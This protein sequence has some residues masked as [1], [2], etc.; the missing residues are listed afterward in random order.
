MQVLISLIMLAGFGLFL[1]LIVG[2]SIGMVADLISPQTDRSK[3]KREELWRMAGDPK[4][5]P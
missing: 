2:I 4:D 5:K 1:L 3:V